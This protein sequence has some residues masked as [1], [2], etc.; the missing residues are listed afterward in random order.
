VNDDQTVESPKR[1][2]PS[3]DP[4]RSPRSALAW[5]LAIMGLALFAYVARHFMLLLVLSATLAY[6]LNPLVKIAESAVVKRH[7]AVALIY[8]GIGFGV[9]IASSYLYPHLRAEVDTLTTSLPFLAERLDDAIDDIQNEIAGGYPA[10]ER[11]FTS[12]EIRYEKLNAF[13]AQQISNVPALL[14]HVALLVL[15]A[16][17][18]PFF[19][20]FFLRDSRKMI[21]FVLDRLPA[22]Q[23][24]TSV[25]VFCEIDRIVGQYLRGVA[26]EGMVVGVTAGLGLWLL[27]IH[28]P[29]LLGVFSGMANVVPYAGP[30]AGGSA[31]MLVALIQFKSLAPLTNVLLLYA[32]IKLVDVVAIQPIALGGGKELHPALLVGSIIVGGQ[33]FGIIGMIIAVPAITIIQKIALLLLERRRY[34]PRLVASRLE[35][36]LPVQPYVC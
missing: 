35:N 5:A 14:T 9:F 32:F 6:V 23:I 1:F 12:R 28:Y 26:I 13:I 21:Q 29:L 7:V 20:Y 10:A 30:I 19:S 16:V 8:L 22:R 3:I 31:A 34:S 17:L 24:E 2:D 33:S 11:W 18:I 4:R 27:G 36:D 15:A 25:A